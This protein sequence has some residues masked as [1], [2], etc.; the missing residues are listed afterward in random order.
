MKTWL[1][2]FNKTIT[3]IIIAAILAPVLWNCMD[4]SADYTRFWLLEPGITNQRALLPF[5]FTSDLYYNY[6]WSENDTTY[7]V[8]NV[9]EWKTMLGDNTQEQDIH[10]IL[11]AHTPAVYFDNKFPKGNSFIKSLNKTNHAQHLQYLNFAKRCEA[12]FS[13]NDWDNKTSEKRAKELVAEGKPLLESAAAVPG[14][15]KRTAYQLMKLYRLAG[16]P[17]ESKLLFEKHFA[18]SAPQNWL[19]AAATYQYAEVQTDP[20]QHN[21]WLARAWDAGF[22]NPIW[23]WHSIEQKSL[24]NAIAAAP[25]GRDKAIL[26]IIPATRQPG[27]ALTE[28]QKAYQFDP[29]VPALSKLMAREVNKLEN[30]LLSPVLYHSQNRIEVPYSEN[31]VKVDS[32]ALLQSDLAHLHACR[33]FV[34]QVL[35]DKKRNDLAFWYLAAAHLA[36][37]DQDFTTAGDLSR[38]GQ[39][40]A[41][42]PANQKIQLEL[43]AVLAEIGGSGKIQEAT[44]N[45]IPGLFLA[46]RQ[47][48]AAFEAPAELQQK[49]AF[50]L[51]DVFIRHHEV[52]K[53]AFLLGK[54]S[55]YYDDLG[56]MASRELFDKLLETG[57]PSDFDRAL[58]MVEKPKTTFE[59]WFSQEPHRYNANMNWDETTQKLK[60]PEGETAKWE[61]EKIREF[62]AMYYTRRD[63]LDSAAI[64]LQHIPDTYWKRTGNV[65]DYDHVYFQTNPFSVDIT[66]PSVALSLP[67]TT[68]KW[69]PKTFL[70]Q[71]ITLRNTTDPAKQQE[72]YFLAGNAYFNMTYHGRDWWLMMAPDKS[73]GEMYYYFDNGTGSVPAA[74]SNP[75]HHILIWSAMGIMTTGIAGLYRKSRRNGWLFLLLLPAFLPLACKPATT[76][77]GTGMPATDQSYTDIYYR[78]TLAKTWYEKAIK[79]N[80]NSDLGIAAAY[81]A[82]V[83]E[84]NQQFYQFSR[85]RKNWDEKFE[86]GP[87]PFY[88]GLKGKNF[89]SPVSCANFKSKL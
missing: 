63:Q 40:M 35:N 5:T 80:P 24:N 75:M 39:Q 42:V 21:I 8:D 15:V 1:N 64:A 27:P 77:S 67:D 7:Q 36:Y 50:L 46:I 86:A 12:V 22:Y 4:Y 58:Q 33:T 66:L 56:Y 62:K 49:L 31:P 11:Y 60:L 37:L 78:C 83:C 87:N 52:A 18:N 69:T 51:S 68:G 29:T 30:W 26:T 6:G 10:S 84:E 14:L 3:G 72:A 89:Q 61:T 54:T 47:N 41:V 71:L 88:E 32:A 59:K 65:S 16:M 76:T 57:K 34:S 17:Q 70:E 55:A 79:I 38:Q 13:P 28:L 48:S 74:P 20:V 9:K 73:I 43:I 23:V 85:A 44:E 25:E 81:M 19:F 82:G 53:G 45:K 2:S